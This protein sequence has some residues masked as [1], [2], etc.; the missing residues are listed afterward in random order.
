MVKVS[1]IVPLF[2]TEKYVA[3]CISSL[4]K[5]TLSD[6][7]IIVVNDGSTD[8]SM[9][10][11]N[12]YAENDSRIKIINQSNQKQGAARNNGLRIA[13]GEYIGFVDSDDWVDE[14]YFEKLYEAAKQYES[15]IALATNVRIGGGKTKKRLNIENVEFV[16]VLQDKFDICKQPKNPCP[17]NKIYRA[18]LLRDNNILFPEKV[19]CEDKLFTAQAVYYANGVVTVPDINYYYYRN[20]NSTVN[21]RKI[22]HSKKL[23]TDKNNANREVLNFLKTKIK[24][25]GAI[26]RDKD[27][28]AIKKEI[29]ILYVTIFQTK[30]SF[31]TQKNLLF[32]LIPISVRSL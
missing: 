28:W 23:I 14:D 31:N 21:I 1:V 10:I 8:N 11:V 29:V 13:E 26:I 7:E 20:P 5:Q 16:T 12:K 17:T 3:R 25:D 19:Y 18:A 9:T 30:E 15:D 27:F 32:G 6:I 22:Q 2:N 24:E 4:V